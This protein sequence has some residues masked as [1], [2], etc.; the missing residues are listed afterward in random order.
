[1]FETCRW[2]A[3]ITHMRCLALQL[4]AISASAAAV[5]SCAPAPD[6]TPDGITREGL[7]RFETI[8]ANADFPVSVPSSWDSLRGYLVVAED[9]ASAEPRELRLP[10]AMVRAR[11]PEPGRAPVLFLPGG[12][13]LGSLSAAA[14]PGAYP[15]TSD[16]DFIVFGRRGSVHAE[17]S[18]MCEQIGDALV[19][20]D[21]PNAPAL[22]DAVT[23]CRETLEAG[24]IDPDQYNSAAHAADIED[25]RQVLDIEQWG[26]FG[27]SYGTRVALTLVRDY[28]DTVESMVLDSPLPHTARYDDESVSN[29]EAAL[30]SVADACEADESCAAAHPNLAERYFA[31]VE[32]AKNEP[33]TLLGEGDTERSV[34][35]AELAGV[36]TLGSRAA[37]ARA[38]LIM[39]AAARL[40][41]NILAP[42]L[43]A[44]GSPSNYAW[45]LRLSVW[46]SEAHPFSER[47]SAPVPEDRFGGL[48]GAVFHP[49]VCEAWDVSQRPEAEIE[50]TR[51]AVPTLI[52][53]GEYDVLTPPRWAD[54]AA[55]FLDRARVVVIPDGFH[56]ETTN[57]GGDGCAMSLAA[58]FFDDPATIVDAPSAECLTGGQPPEFVVRE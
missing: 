55:R 26:L 58:A 44:R 4:A 18:L 32:R 16:R 19:R 24:G 12:P 46:C 17:P 9:R 57:W 47:A 7:P 43:D 23:T 20:A 48:D 22:I 15:W 50:P 2:L 54:D 34:S 3:A 1:M 10:V 39:D 31:Q 14:Y 27:L 37:L 11:T 41:G 36:T 5:S 53:A 42:L 30:R 25:L 51:S 33:L 21:R 29:Y 40:D 35:A 6:A 28:P 52:I 45:G 8:D 49:D 38:P 56:G 13:G